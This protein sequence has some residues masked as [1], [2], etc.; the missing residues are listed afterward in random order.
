MYAW[1]MI[2]VFTA[3]IC[4][5][6]I[7][8][9]PMIIRVL[10]GWLRG[11]STSKSKSSSPASY[12]LKDSNQSRSLNLDEESLTATLSP[13]NVVDA[14]IYPERVASRWSR[15]FG[16]HYRHTSTI[17]ESEEEIASNTSEKEDLEIVNSI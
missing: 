13:E 2:E 17:M 12:E 6:L 11:G 15:T 5:C 4:S 1:S 16:D 14:P 10:P 8:Y 3:V 7:C 9:R